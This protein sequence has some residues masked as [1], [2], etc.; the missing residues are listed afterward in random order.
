[1]KNEDQLLIFYEPDEYLS[2]LWRDKIKMNAYGI[3]ISNFGD[4]SKTDVGN[5]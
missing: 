5:S 3:I 1:M 4:D 2:P